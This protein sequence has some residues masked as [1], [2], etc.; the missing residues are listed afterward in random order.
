MKQQHWV[1]A[2]GLI[3]ILV[4]CP[5]PNP[6]VQFTI[7]ANAGANGNVS[8]STQKV[9]SGAT[10]TITVTANAGFSISSVTGCGGNLNANLYTTAAINADCTVNATFA[11]NPPAATTGTTN[12]AVTGAGV[13]QASRTSKYRVS[14]VAAPANG[15]PLVIYLHGDGDANVQVPSSYTTFT[16]AQAAVL[17]SPQGLNAT[18]RFRMDGKDNAGAAAEVDDIAFIKEIIT[19]GSSAAN[20]LFGAGNK[21]DPAKV[22]VVGESRGAG[23]AYYLY[24]HPETKN[25]ITA[26]APISGTFYCAT[27]NG[28][29]GT[30]PYNPPADSD[31]VCGE[32]GGFGYFGPKSSLYTR[33]S[34]PRIFN[35]HGSNDLAETAAP[36]LDN[37]YGNLIIVTKQWAASSS[38]C[39]NVLPSANPV[40]SNA[41]IGGKTVTAYKQRNAANNAACEAD[42]TFFIVQ[43]GGHVPSGYAERITKWFFG[44]YNT[45]T[46]TFN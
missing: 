38:N 41:N 37:E 18:W 19:R 14:G 33:V 36:A 4:A 30:L 27:S 15:R 11:A 12:F 13:L 24:A 42:V 5:S 34:P 40:F 20:P 10:A 7:T 21:I 2:V 35:I 39:G 46:N 9:N 23:F 43:A 31:F 26:I 16:D 44:Q 25:L 6:T 45:Q 32:N 29:N 28:G 17:V 1:L 3:G 22:F 8:P